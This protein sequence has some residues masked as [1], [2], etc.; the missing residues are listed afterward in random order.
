[1]LLVKRSGT[2]F[3]NRSNARSVVHWRTRNSTENSSSLVMAASARGVLVE[4]WN[5]RQPDGTIRPVGFASRALTATQMKWNVSRIEAW[6]IVFMLRYFYWAINPRFKHIIITDRAALKWMDSMIKHHSPSNPQLVRFSL[7]INQSGPHLLQHRAGTANGG[8]DAMSR[9][10]ATDIS[11]DG[12]RDRSNVVSPQPDL[13][14]DCRYISEC[15]ISRV[16][17]VQLPTLSQDT[18]CVTRHRATC[19]GTIRDRGTTAE[20]AQPGDRVGPG[21]H[22][23]AGPRLLGSAV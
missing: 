4:S 15:S 6:C 9:L 16:L 23:A 21:G 7:E 20:Q 22:R 11:I 8:P 13:W 19:F 2:I 5:K 1:M 3:S 10:V 12:R 18:A 14:S 17:V